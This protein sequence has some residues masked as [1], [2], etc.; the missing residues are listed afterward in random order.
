MIKNTPNQCMGNT[1]IFSKFLIA[2][3]LLKNPLILLLDK[4][5]VLKVPKYTTKANIK[6]YTR[7]KTTDI[8]DAVVVLSGNEYPKELLGLDEQNL[9]VVLDCGGHIGTFAMYVKQNYPSA[10]V[11][12]LEP[13]PEN[14]ELFLR[15]ISLNNMV[16]VTL[17]KYALSGEH[18]QFYIDLSNKQFDAVSLQENK[19]LHRNF[20]EVTALTFREVVSSYGLQRVDLLKMDVEGAEYDILGKTLSSM[21]EFVKRI[22]M[23]YHPAGDKVHNDMLKKIF[24]DQHWQLVYETKNILGFDNPRFYEK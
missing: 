4:L 23:E 9:P 8:N 16:G 13:V 7:G 18:G 24:D 5:G 10:L 6:F 19:P 15:N 11:Y 22:I 14:Q 1:S 20:V 21:N 17:V 3:R 2:F 12:S